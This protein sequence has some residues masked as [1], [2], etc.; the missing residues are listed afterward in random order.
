MESRNIME[1][2]V[3]GYMES[4][5]MLSDFNSLTEWQ[6][7]QVFP[8]YASFVVPKSKAADSVED[9]VGLT[10]GQMMFVSEAE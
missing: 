9:S 2:F 5:R 6:R 10:A 7:L 1:E 3:K 4:G 8:K